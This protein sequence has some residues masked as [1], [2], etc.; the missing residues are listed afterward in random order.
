M[1][2]GGAAAS[3]E[4][5]RSAAAH[6][7]TPAQHVQRGVRLEQQ[8]K[9][10]E[11]EREFRIA[12]HQDTNSVGAAVGHAEA[13]VQIGQP[14]DALL[15]LQSFLREHSEAARAHYFYAVV[16][17]IT[18]NDFLAAQKEMEECVRLDPSDGTA[19]KS[20]GDIYLDHTT[21]SEA[22]E[23][24]KKA[25]QLLPRDP[26]IVAS[27]AE[28]Y[29]E[30]GKVPEAE[31]TFKEAIEMTDGAPDS[32]DARKNRGAVQYLFAQ[33]LLKQD[34][35]ADSIAAATQALAYNPHSAVTLYHRARAYKA[36]G[37][38]KHAEQDAL[39]AYRLVP[40][41]KQGP[42]LLTDIY[43]K[44]HD[45]PNVEKYAAIAQKLIDAEQQ[46]AAF[47]REVR[48][49]LGV[50]EEALK[51]GH[52]D[53]AISPYQDLI[54]KVPTFYEA[55]FGLGICYSQT[56]RLADAE[57]SFR[58]YLSFQRVSG[59]GHAALGV[60]LL[61]EGKSAEGVP[62]LEQ[63]LRIDPTLDEARKAL[64]NEYLRKQQPDAAIRVL[65][66]AQN[67]EDP[68][69]KVMLASGFLQKGDVAGAK[70][71]IHFALAL[72]PDDP[73]AL[74]LQQEIL[75]KNAGK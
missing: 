69:I 34:R 52:F 48:R 60:L 27:L 13:L 64:A 39:D 49:L 22:V 12:Y 56:G 62:E 16:I 8:K 75:S 47:G 68:Q 71:E 23:A 26:L 25:R 61:E 67:R 1:L 20:L 59:D 65:R 24:Y 40:D 41:G 15:E 45:L 46:R 37:D 53:D 30:A 4:A 2:A 7:E 32:P 38:Y 74:K 58:K 66:A 10:E 72:Q 36:T 6:A 11:A 3:L 55:Y 51:Q 17:L 21:A 73:D 5:Q 9:W 70:R 19:W 28:A 29:S 63:A 54:Q 14:F 18:S 31:A 42:L 33:Y 44:L 50:A 43:R 57:A 35:A